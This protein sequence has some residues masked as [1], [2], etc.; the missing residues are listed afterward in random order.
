[1][2][3]LDKE[4]VGHFSCD[5]MSHVDVKMLKQIADILDPDPANTEDYEFLHIKS[6]DIRYKL[7]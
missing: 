7:V 1:M 6:S 5:N 2:Q 3:L 4:H